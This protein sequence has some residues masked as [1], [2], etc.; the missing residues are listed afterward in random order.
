M[1]LYSIIYYI[2]NYVYVCVYTLNL[3]ED[4]RSSETAIKMVGNHPV[5][6]LGSELSSFGRAENALNC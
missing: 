5:W 1:F 6:V 3:E 4:I 2:F